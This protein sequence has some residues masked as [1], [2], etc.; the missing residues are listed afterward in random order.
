MII[1]ALE[2]TKTTTPF[3][4][5][6]MDL[7]KK[8]PDYLV[9][10][11]NITRLIL[12]TAGFALLF[13]NLYTPFGSKEWIPNVSDLKFFFYSNLIILTGVLVVVI[14]RIVMY[15][16]S[17][18]GRKITLGNYLMWVAIEI[19]SMSLFYTIYEQMIII[20]D[21]RSF[22]E[23]FKASLSNTSL[24][25]LLPYSTLWLYFSWRDKNKKLKELIQEES[26]PTETKGMI[27][28][29][30]DR[31]NLRFSIKQQ[32]V[33]YLKGAD[34][35]VTIYYNDHHK[36][37]HL[38]LRSTLKQMEEELKEYNII[39]C[40]R[41]F[42]TNMD[43]IKLIEKDKEGMII[44]LDHMQPTEVPVSKT[45]IQEVFKFFG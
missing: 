15:Q 42:M 41:S 18:R 2:E 8:I 21:A 29:K 44:R 11:G 19:V 30:D 43:R 4:S 37:E 10:K 9:E 35:Y 27:P 34:N 14:S 25:L 23:V 39:R 36:V 20:K 1:F 3:L 31:G 5:P 26:K 12:L 28:F 22:I 33:L 7:S 45:Y 40:H 6:D 17:K 13:I 38:M 24:V 32:D 16:A